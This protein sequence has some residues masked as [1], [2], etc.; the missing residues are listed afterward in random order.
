VIDEDHSGLNATS[1]PLA[2]FYVRRK[3]RS[4]QTVGRIV[5][6]GDR[7]LLVGDTEKQGYPTKEFFKIGRGSLLDVG[8]D[9]GLHKG[10][11][12]IDSATTIMSRAPL[13]T[14]RLCPA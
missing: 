7:F 4:T 14:E 9:R 6:E 13:A 12:A 11:G 10:P 2:S 3:Y 8:E 1:H 5:G